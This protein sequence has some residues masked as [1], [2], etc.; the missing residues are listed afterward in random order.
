MMPWRPRFILQPSSCLLPQE[1][2]SPGCPHHS[3]DPTARVLSLSLS[4]STP[5]LLLFLS[6][7]HTKTH[8]PSHSSLSLALSLPTLSCCA[9][10]SGTSP[11]TGSWKHVF[12][13]V[14]LS[15]YQFSQVFLFVFCIPKWHRGLLVRT[16]SDESRINSKL[17][18]SMRI[19]IWVFTVCHSI[20]SG[21]RHPPSGLWSR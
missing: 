15:V 21:I 8:P 6:L 11:F 14:V 10:R 16:H 1:C 2:T 19:Y 9:D 5:L 7:T 3:L 18:P 20:T 4:L 12:R 13:F 17:F